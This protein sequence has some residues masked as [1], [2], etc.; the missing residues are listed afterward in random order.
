MA[1]ASLARTLR[2][3]AMWVVPAVLLAEV[4]LFAVRAAVPAGVLEASNDVVGNYLQTLGSIYAVLLAFVVFVVWN[5]FNEAR[6]HVEREANELVDLCR[7][8][9]GLP[10]PIRTELPRLIGHYIEA[11]VDREWPAMARYDD[12]PLALGH[13]ILDGM[14][15][16]LHACPTANDCETALFS[17]ALARFNGLSDARTNRLTSNRQRIPLPIVVLMYMGAVA[18]VGSIYLF[19]VDRALVH[20]LITG[21]TAGG[22][23]HLLYV[24]DDLDHCFAGAW[25]VPRSA[26][27]RAAVQ[28]QASA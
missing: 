27:E 12:G 11:V 10:E 22:L 17:E 7:I 13:S 19:E 4:G 6:G 3:V 23:S 2:G 21:A 28:I 14:W 20:A 25:Q 26:F 5:Q 15:N 1:R 18:L 16:L 24:V 9:R 8:S